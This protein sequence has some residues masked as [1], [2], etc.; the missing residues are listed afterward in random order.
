M[1]VD[2]RDHIRRE[3]GF[4]RIIKARSLASKRKSIRSFQRPKINFPATYYI[5]MIHWNTITLSPPP[6]LQTFSNQE[7]WSKIQ[8]VGT[9]AEWNFDK[10]PCYTQAVERCV[11]LVTEASQKAIGSNFRD[12]FIRTTLLSRSSMPSFSRHVGCQNS[13]KTE[14]ELAHIRHSC[15][16]GCSPDCVKLKYPY[17]VVVT[18]NELNMETG[19]KDEK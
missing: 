18:E 3:L 8:S 5:E 13:S 1:T 17:T 11:K 19:L 2:K 10:F 12:C 4:R 7:I 15:L 16:M 14:T 6:L 9:A